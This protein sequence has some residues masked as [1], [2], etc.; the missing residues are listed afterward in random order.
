MFN[1][2]DVLQT[3]SGGASS[4]IYDGV[5]C[6]GKYQKQPLVKGLHLHGLGPQE[7]V[8]LNRTE[9]NLRIIDCARATILGR[10]TFE[11][12]VIV[13]GKDLRRGGFLGFLTRLSTK[14]RHGLY[15]HDSHS[16]VMSDFYIEQ[17]D[18]GFV[19]EGSPD[20]PPGRITLQGGKLQ[21]NI[22]EDKPHEGTAM[23]VS[24]YNGQVFCGH[25]QFYTRPPQIRIVKKGTSPTEL[26]IFASIFYRTTLDVQGDKSLQVRLLGNESIGEVTREGK[27]SR[28][29]SSVIDP[30]TARQSIARAFDDLRL[31]GEIDLQL[32]Y[33]EN[34]RDPVPHPSRTQ[35]ACQPE[36]EVYVQLPVSRPPEITRRRRTP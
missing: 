13:E 7:V 2:I 5:F 30:E 35:T 8:V 27:V 22:P 10:T 3:G 12:S 31:L 9:G 20:Q 34:Q 28:M 24:N 23:M 16:I 26:F 21:F 6:F 29:K 11:G 32:S 1:G 25:N 14:T 17:A 18:N 4:M 19:F 33:P 36:S 15:V